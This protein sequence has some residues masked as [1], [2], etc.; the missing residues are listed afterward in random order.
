MKQR[1][2]QAI[3]SK[4]IRE[5]AVNRVQEERLSAEA[6]AKQLMMPKSTLTACVTYNCV[7]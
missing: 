1:I 2:L 7:K 5:Q 4:K 3:Y 6:V